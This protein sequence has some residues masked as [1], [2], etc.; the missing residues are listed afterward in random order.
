MKRREFLRNTTAV[1]GS[2]VF[3]GVNLP[4]ALWAQETP[5]KGSTLIWG[6]SE[7]TQNLDMHQTGTASSG[8]VLQNIHSSIVTVDKD[9]NVIPG[10]CESFEVAMVVPIFLCFSRLS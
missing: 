1:L 2:G 4:A 6:H 10:L 9:L 7:T 5:V 8:R 3:M